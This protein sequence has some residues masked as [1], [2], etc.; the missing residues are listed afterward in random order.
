MLEVT[1][2]EDDIEKPV[3]NLEEEEDEDL[4]EKVQAMRK[5]VE[6]QLGVS[7][8]FDEDELKYEVLLEKVKEMVEEN[9]EEIASLLEALLS[10]ENE[11]VKDATNKG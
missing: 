7:E 8:N 5:K 9:T 1:Q 3:L 11:N 2:E 10:E 4:V 6:Q